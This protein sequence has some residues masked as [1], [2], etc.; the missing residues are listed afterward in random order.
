M[1]VK[2]N[3]RLPAELEATDRFHKGLAEAVEPL[4]AYVEQL[5]GPGAF[6]PKKGVGDK[7]VVQAD[8]GGV[9]IVLTGYGA[10]LIEYG[11][12]NTPARAP[13]RRAAHAAGLELRNTD[14]KQ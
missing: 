12:K 11:S 7:V 8:R 14:R 9:R 4:A 13:L 3:L 6:M 1:K 2:P 10:H 5:R